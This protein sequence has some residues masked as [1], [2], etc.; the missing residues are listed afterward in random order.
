VAG[1]YQLA[2]ASNNDRHKKRDNDR[3][4]RHRD[5]A[6][7]DDEEDEIRKA[8]ELSKVTAQREEEDRLKEKAMKTSKLKENSGR[9]GSHAKHDKDF[10]FGSG[11]EQFAAYNNGAAVGGDNLDDFDFGDHP[12]P[13]K[14]Q[15]SKDE[16]NFNFG[17]QKNAKKEEKKQDHVGD[18]LDLDFSSSQPEPKQNI[19]SNSG[20]ADFGDIFGGNLGRNSAGVDPFGG[21][22]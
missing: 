16:F 17:G 13:S 12:K 8:I 2:S 18:L 15:P 10:D 1:S 20:N 11:F 6:A 7:A 9:V 5:R 22:A 19:I 3:H 21:S 4:H 14:N